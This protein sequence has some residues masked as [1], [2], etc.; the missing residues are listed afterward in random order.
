MKMCSVWEMVA[1]GG[2]EEFFNCF[3]SCP[4][5]LFWNFVNAVDPENLTAGISTSGLGPCAWESQL[6]WDPGNLSL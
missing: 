2:K 3:Q 1:G 5:I 4:D 6:R